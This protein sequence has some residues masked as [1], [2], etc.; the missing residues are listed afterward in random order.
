VETA[1]EEEEDLEEG[2]VA[3]ELNA[4]NLTRMHENKG[5]IL[6]A[7]KKRG[8]VVSLDPSFN[9]GAS[10]TVGTVQLEH[11]AEQ[12]LSSDELM[13]I[14]AKRLGLD[15]NLV[16]PAEDMHSVFSGVSDGNALASVGSS[17]TG[18]GV[19]LAPLAPRGPRISVDKK[20]LLAEENDTVDQDFDS[21]DDLWS[22]DDEI[23][24]GDIDAEEL[25]NNVLP[26]DHGEMAALKR[27]FTVCLSDH[28]FMGLY[29]DHNHAFKSSK[30]PGSKHL[31]TLQATKGIHVPFL[32]LLDSEVGSSGFDD[33]HAVANWRRLPRPNIDKNFF[34]K[35]GYCSKPTVYLVKYN[36]NR[37][38]IG[39]ERKTLG[40]DHL[41]ANTL[42]APVA[43]V[44]IGA[45]E[46]IQYEPDPF[47]AEYRSIFVPNSKKDLERQ[48]ATLARNIARVCYFARLPILLVRVISW[49]RC[50]KRYSRRIYQLTTSSCSV[51]PMS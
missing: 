3:D 34:A 11:I 6:E 48:L 2:E 36:V 1:E 22:E 29:R 25:D 13:R 9:G 37:F 42:N 33:N 5:A 44:P 21:D 31:S 19:G 10:A 16:I 18:S 51:R 46:A 14:L 20:I 24:A 23:E 17:E 15:A 39:T 7:Q 35:C 43:L 38:Y 41:A 8:S 28:K 27:L 49:L 32:N 12:L 47:V 45:V 30:E 4:G 50:R 40:P 26:T